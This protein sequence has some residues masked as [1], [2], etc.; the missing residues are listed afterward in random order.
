MPD[1]FRR[2]TSEGTC[3]FTVIRRVDQ[4]S[5][6]ES[7]K[8]K[9][10]MIGTGKVIPSK[11]EEQIGA[12]ARRFLLRQ[13]GDYVLLI[14]DLEADRA[15][16]VDG[17][18]RRYRLALTTMLPAELRSK[19]AVHFFVNMLEAYYF[20]DAAAIN[21]VLGTEFEDFTGDVETIQH[22]KNELKSL[23]PRFDEME[24]GVE[25][26]GK[27]DIAHV[28]G[29]RDVCASLRTMFTWA[30]EAVGVTDW[31]L[32][33]RLFDATKD[34]IEALRQALHGSGG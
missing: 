22:P 9:L 18:F 31:L 34:Q 19:V 28:L 14:D 23:Y 15:A 26:V 1:L 13:G 2:L 10:R 17:I 11:D 32:E 16:R 8:R 27:L 7:P 33:G 29:P 20:A 25:I 5:P 30:G 3:S 4:R 6:V 12:P 21:S 24:H